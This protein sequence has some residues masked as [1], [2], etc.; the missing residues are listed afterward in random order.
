MYESHDPIF[1]II[2]QAPLVSYCPEKYALI[3]SIITKIN[4][5]QNK[6]C[7]LYF[8]NKDNVQKMRN[9]FFEEL[10]ISIQQNRSTQLHLSNYLEEE[11]KQFYSIVD[12]LKNL[13]ESYKISIPKIQRL[14]IEFNKLVEYWMILEGSKDP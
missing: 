8:M 10:K 4:Y 14:Q 12:D 5:Q 1:S 3:Q 6:I 2:H 13:H 11:E 7:T 9:D